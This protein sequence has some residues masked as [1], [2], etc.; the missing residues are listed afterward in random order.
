MLDVVWFDR[1]YIFF[2][3]KSIIGAEK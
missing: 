1:N 3:S 2:I